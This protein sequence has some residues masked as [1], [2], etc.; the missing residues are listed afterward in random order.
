VILGFWMNLHFITTGTAERRGERAFV[1][2]HVS[3]PASGRFLPRVWCAYAQ[4][5]RPRYSC[6]LLAIA[7]AG[8]ARQEAIRVGCRDSMSRARG[9]RRVV[10]D[11]PGTEREAPVTRFCVVTRDA[12]ALLTRGRR[13]FRHTHWRCLTSLR[14]HSGQLNAGRR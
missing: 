2:H 6:H 11:M 14:A 7:R 12:K 8:G 1:D 4:R 3:F 5:A 10:R 13:T 9:S